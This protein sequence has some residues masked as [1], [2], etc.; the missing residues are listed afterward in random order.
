MKILHKYHDNVD[1]KYNRVDYL[2][3]SL[4]HSTKHFKTKLLYY[5]SKY[6]EHLIEMSES[7]L[8]Y[9]YSMGQIGESD[10]IKKR[11][12]SI[13]EILFYYNKEYEQIVSFDV[14]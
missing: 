10:K 2:V 9:Y 12:D 3:I 13:N 11:I 14:L 7:E 8:G 1:I 4:N 6:D 5:L